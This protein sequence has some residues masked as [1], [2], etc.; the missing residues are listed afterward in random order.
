MRVF[1]RAYRPFL[2]GGNCNANLAAEIET[3]RTVTV[4]SYTLHLI[5]SPDGKKEAWVDDVSGGL[6]GGNLG[7]VENDIAKADRTFLDLQLEE[8]R[9]VGEAAEPVDADEF[10]SH[11]P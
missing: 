3:V 7:E 11:V 5:V 4:H 8:Q 10:W 9:I 1:T 2:M 6:V